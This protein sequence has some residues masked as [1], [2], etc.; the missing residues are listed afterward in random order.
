MR[1]RSTF[2][3]LRTMV[4]AK[5]RACAAERTKL[6]CRVV[7]L[8]LRSIDWI[9]PSATHPSEQMPT[10]GRE[11]GC[12]LCAIIQLTLQICNKAA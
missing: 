7:T 1:S 12:A 3:T 2:L 11:I 4:S 5:S 6:T 8:D 9:K 10:L